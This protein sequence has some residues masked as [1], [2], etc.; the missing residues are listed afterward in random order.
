MVGAPE[1]KIRSD[2]LTQRQLESGLLLGQLAFGYKHWPNINKVHLLSAFIYLHFNLS[3]I[4]LHFNELNTSFRFFRIELYL[5]YFITPYFI[6]ARDTLSYFSLLGL[7]AAICLSPSVIT[8]TL[9][10]WAILVFFVGRFVLEL[11][12]CYKSVPKRMSPSMH[13]QDAKPAYR[14]V[15]SIMFHSYLRCVQQI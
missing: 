13:H 5:E 4:Y 14:S 11:D 6:F 9:V 12:Q 7:H 2:L 15:K 10:E 8:F 1:F 3:F